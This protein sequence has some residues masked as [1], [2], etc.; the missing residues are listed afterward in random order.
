MVKKSS[1]NAS[2]APFLL[3][4]YEMV[5]DPS[6]DDLISWSQTNDSFIV[7]DESNFASQLLPKF[8][9]HSNYASFQRQL[10]IY[11][12]RKT[13]TDRWEF[14]NDGFIKGQKHLLK[15]ISRKKA[16]QVTVQQKVIQ[17][18]DPE[19]EIIHVSRDDENRHAHLWKE[20]ES[21]KTDKN[22]LMQE[23]VKQRQH[24][25]TSRTK[26]LV[27]REQLKGMEKNQH[28]LLSFIVM[29]MQS[30]GF[31]AQLS[32]QIQSKTIIK[33]VTEDTTDDTERVVLPNERAIVKYQPPVESP[34]YISED[35]VEMGLTLEEIEDI[36]MNDDTPGSTVDSGMDSTENCDS[37]TIHDLPNC[38]SMIDELLSSPLEKNKITVDH[39]E[40]EVWSSEMETDAY[41]FLTEGFE[42][43]L[44][45]SPRSG[46]SLLSAFN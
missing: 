14:A 26:M 39:T 24:Q 44:I 19:P 36:L 45:V 41:R 18:K 30:P 1:E 34:A 15:S 20:V 23:L 46:T 32:P 29:A 25:E 43:S 12:F 10:N 7:W 4:C 9:K 6:T 16:T 22:M 5:D 27:L 8:F 3:K 2:I 13:D 33:P 35:S 31:F 11:G 17:Q 28:Q 42:K 40:D 38:D 21:L 37:V